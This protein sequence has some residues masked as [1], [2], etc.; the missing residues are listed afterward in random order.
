MP[1]SPSNPSD[2][3]LEV[4]DIEG[5][6][7]FAQRPVHVH[8]SLEHI[9]ALQRLAQ[10][11]LENPDMLL[12]ELVNSAI[13]LCGAESAG[14]SME[15]AD[16]TEESYY[17]WVATAGNYAPFMDAILP[18]HPSACTVCLERGRPQV[19]RVSQRFFELM[20]IEAIP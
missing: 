15:R 13:N 10:C 14:I 2:T 20:G 18:R 12:Q 5:D 16:K 3:G 17:H 6:A 4:I 7:A 9:E 1:L 19:F 11:F 8:A